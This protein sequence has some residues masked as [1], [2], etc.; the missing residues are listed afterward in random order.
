MLTLA[1]ALLLIVVVVNEAQY[2][3]YND[4]LTMTNNLLAESSE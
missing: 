1:G 3:L 4:F 2:F